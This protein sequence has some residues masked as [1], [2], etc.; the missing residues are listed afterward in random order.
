MAMQLAV[1]ARSG[2]HQGSLLHVYDVRALGSEDSSSVFVFVALEAGQTQR[3]R[4]DVCRQA[5]VLAPQCGREAL[6]PVG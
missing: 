4:A 5:T 1:A 2:E 6:Q 3:L